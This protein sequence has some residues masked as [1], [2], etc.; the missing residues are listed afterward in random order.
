MSK[1][2]EGAIVVKCRKCFGTAP[3]MPASFVGDILEGLRESPEDTLS[4]PEEPAET[5]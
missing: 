3:K 1:V 5:L 4:P 2:L